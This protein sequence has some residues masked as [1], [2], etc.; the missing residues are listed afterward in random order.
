M[1]SGTEVIEGKSAIDGLPELTLKRHGTLA[2]VFG[3]IT[4]TAAGLIGVGGGEFR[5]PVLLYLFGSEPKTAA[6]VN[7]IIGLFT[8]C[9]AFIR[10]RSQHA[11]AMEDIILTSTLP[12]L[13]LYS[14]PARPIDGPHRYFA[15]SFAFT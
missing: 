1:I 12:C 8:V 2:A 4:G 10:R 14:V 13:V 6:G 7:L 5:I 3:F 15:T 11:W 9:F